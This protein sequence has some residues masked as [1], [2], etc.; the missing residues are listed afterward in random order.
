L[1]TIM[2]HWP[3]E[4]NHTL[5]NC[6]FFTV[7]LFK[8]VPLYDV[9]IA[10][11]VVVLFFWLIVKLRGHLIVLSLTKNKGM[12]AA[13]I[14]L[15]VVGI[16][17]VGKALVLIVGRTPGRATQSPYF[18]IAWAVTHSAAVSLE[19]YIDLL[20]IVLIFGVKWTGLKIR[21]YSTVLKIMA[22][23]A[24]IA[25]C[26]DCSIKL[27]I[28][29]EVGEE[30]DQIKSGRVST[31]YWLLRESIGVILY[32]VM[33]L[34]VA[35]SLKSENSNF[36]LHGLRM[37]VMPVKWNHLL[38]L[39]VLLS[40]YALST[41]GWVMVFYSIDAATCVVDSSNLVFLFVFPPMVYMT[42]MSKFF[43][44]AEHWPLMKQQHKAK[45]V[46]VGTKSERA[47]FLDPEN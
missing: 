39:S 32:I 25:A 18:K 37:R 27:F 28:L 4:T 11:P 43:Q 22:I 30:V 33:F 46:Q 10:L 45:R 21:L 24:I 7:L 9:V 16:L 26:L 29:F 35:F 36:G 3:T 31:I 5:A 20:V 41:S 13:L 23:A 19:V 2:V 38:V 40:Q 12:K 15:W 14:F 34:V 47:P 1:H 6:D 17:N 42:L 44:K 8:K